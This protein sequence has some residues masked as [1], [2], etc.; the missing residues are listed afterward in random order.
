MDDTQQVLQRFASKVAP[1]LDFS[2]PE[3]LSS[4]IK[5]FANDLKPLK[6]K[7]V[8]WA[9]RAATTGRVHGADL[10]KTVHLLGPRRVLY[11]VEQAL[12][13]AANKS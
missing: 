9:I 5:T 7:T 8:M 3:N 1:N 13:V 12:Q 11:R 4:Q 6:I 2:S 10:G